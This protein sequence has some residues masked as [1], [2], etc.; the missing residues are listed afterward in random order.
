MRNAKTHLAVCV[1]ML[2]L[3]SYAAFAAG[4]SKIVSDSPTNGETV[5]QTPGLGPVAII[6]FHTE[7]FTIEPL[8]G[9][10]GPA[11]I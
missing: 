9:H 5:Q 8:A 4:E 6:K 2:S 10:A 7:N 11:D 1:M 3:F